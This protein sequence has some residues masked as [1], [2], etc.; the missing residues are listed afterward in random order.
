MCR[1]LAHVSDWGTLATS[2]AGSG[3]PYGGVVSVSDG[4]PGAPSGRLYFYLTVSTRS[5]PP[6]PPT[7]LG[8]LQPGPAQTPPCAQALP[9]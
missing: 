7:H 9:P 2:D 4:A 1:W 5:L 3:A 6:S 8:V